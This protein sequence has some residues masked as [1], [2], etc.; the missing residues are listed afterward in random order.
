MKADEPSAADNLVAIIDQLLN[1]RLPRAAASVVLD[2]AEKVRRHSLHNVAE[3]TAPA[4]LY[5]ARA[6]EDFEA[7]IKRGWELINRRADD[8]G[9]NWLDVVLDARAYLESEIA[10]LCTEDEDKDRWRAVFT[11]ALGSECLADVI[12]RHKGQ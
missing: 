3:L 5:F 2:A 1:T 10:S 12:E 9:S 7:A 8:D 11:R 6:I 4:A